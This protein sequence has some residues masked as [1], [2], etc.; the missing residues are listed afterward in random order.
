[1]W[2][3]LD[4]GSTVE[5]MMD[6]SPCSLATYI[7]VMKEYLQIATSTV[8][9]WDDGVPGVCGALLVIRISG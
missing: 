8:Q 6:K 7:L 5:S 3:V 2:S 1:M 4:F 9:K